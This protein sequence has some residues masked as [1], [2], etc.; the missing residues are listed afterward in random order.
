MHF[1]LESCPVDRSKTSIQ[2]LHKPFRSFMNLLKEFEINCDYHENGCKEYVKLGQ[3]FD[4]INNCH[5]DPKL[6]VLCDCGVIIETNDLIDHQN[7]CNKY[8]RKQ[9]RYSLDLI[10]SMNVKMNRLDKD[11]KEAKKEITILSEWERIEEF[12]FIESDMP[13]NMK[14]GIFNILRGFLNRGIFDA[15]DVCEKFCEEFGGN[16]TVNVGNGLVNNYF[17][18]KNYIL[19]KI[20]RIDVMI[21]MNIKPVNDISILK[22][23][24]KSLDRGINDNAWNEDMM[25]TWGLFWSLTDDSP[26]TSERLLDKNVL[27]YFMKCNELF[28]YNE[29]NLFN[30]MFG[31]LAN[32]SDFKELRHRIMKPEFI[33]IILRSLTNQ[34]KLISYTSANLLANVLSEGEAFWGKY[35]K[36]NTYLNRTSVL[37]A[38]KSEIS[39][40][41]MN[42]KELHISFN[43]FKPFNRLL[44]C[45]DRIPQE[46][47]Y[48]AVWSLAHFTR[49][50]C[51][52]YCL[53]F[54]ED[55]CFTVIE[56]LIKCIKTEEYIKKLA[57]LILYDY[58]CFLING[59]L[60]ELKNSDSID[61]PA[62]NQN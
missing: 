43:S 17:Y 44:E 28:P 38:L 55:F 48:F 62:L 45:N 3:L 53:L 41:K 5:F 14:D 7:N 24:F 42:S 8:L 13:Y 57:Q 29:Q 37:A 23:L 58:R 33:S 51:E 12:V 47:Q 6:R 22:K 9:L 34:N 61:I 52:R 54:E 11:L 56:E 50:N 20:G 49:K 15:E 10:N 26:N 16:W 21:S 46:V 36:Q 18:R 60:G 30:P 39:E 59:S 40:W 35:F 4:H 19:L 31:A 25:N 32:I 2:N 1:Y 27:D